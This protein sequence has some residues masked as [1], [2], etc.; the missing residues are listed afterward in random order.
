MGQRFIWSDRE[1]PLLLPPDLREWLPDDHL[2]WFVID[3]VEQFDLAAFYSAYRADGHGRPAHDPAVMV[4]LFVYAYSVGVRSSRRVERACAEDVAF[5]VICANRAPDHSTIARFRARHE[6]ALEGLFGQVLG[7][8]A[9]SGLVSVG[10]VAVD[11]TK[12]KAD[13]AKGQ[14]RSY[15]QIAREIFAEAARI[16]AEEDERFGDAR[17]DELPPELAD[18]SS[19][20]ARLREAKARLEAEQAEKAERHEQRMQTRQAKELVDGRR[21]P[22]PAPVAPSLAV[23]PQERV[24]VTDPDSR[25]M[26]SAQGWVQG[27]NAQVAATAEQII[28]AAELTTSS[29]DQ[30][31]LQPMVRTITRELDAAGVTE[32]IGTVLADSGYWDTAQIEAIISREHCTVLVPPDGE[33]RRAAGKTGHKHDRGLT[34]FLRRVIDSEAGRA[35]YR[36]R[37]GIIEPVFGDLK[38]NRGADRFSR[39]GHAA[40]RSELRLLAATHNLLKLHRAALAT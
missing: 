39:R 25:M 32:P 16:D 19:R 3:A 7:L 38:H 12:L 34:A 15:E 1:Q 40:C 23:D 31:C 2:A 11:G 30:G 24:N 37:Q 36:R 9:E 29:P 33:T 4:A 13:A 14:T 6:A 21:M 10:V 5:R 18:R 8:C 27:Y 35:L 17:G 22:G 20:L 28:V 26:R